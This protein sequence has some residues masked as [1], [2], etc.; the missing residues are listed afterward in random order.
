MERI[1]HA[2]VEALRLVTAFEGVS[3]AEFADAAL[4]PVLRKRHR[5][6]VVKEARKVE[7][8]EK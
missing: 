5:D 2:I 1:S 3:V 4:L 8:G 6:A 7:G